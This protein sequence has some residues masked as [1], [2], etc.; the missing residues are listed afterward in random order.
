MKAI[1]TNVGILLALFAIYYFDLLSLFTF[2]NARLYAF[3]LVIIMLLIGLKVF[4]NP[5]GKR[6]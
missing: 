5:F 6:K 2:K 3:G 1:L 4:G